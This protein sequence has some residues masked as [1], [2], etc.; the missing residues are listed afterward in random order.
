MVLYGKRQVV[1]DEDEEDMSNDVEDT[2]LFS[3]RLFS[4]NDEGNLEESYM[5]DNHDEMI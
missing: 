5:R 3:L 1:D 2:P 4:V